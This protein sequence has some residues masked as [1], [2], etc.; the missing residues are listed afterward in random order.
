LVVYKELTVGLADFT[1]AVHPP[2]PVRLSYRGFLGDPGV[3]GTVQK[4]REVLE[5]LEV[6]DGNR[7]HE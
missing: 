6:S 7:E 5:R 1:V 2:L 4:D 3:L